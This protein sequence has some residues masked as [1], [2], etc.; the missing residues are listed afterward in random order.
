M[1]IKFVSF[2]AFIFITIASSCKSNAQQ[3]PLSDF[4][5]TAP[6][7]VYSDDWYKLD[8]SLLQF[9]VYNDNGI[10]RLDKAPQEAHAEL[11]VKGGKLIGINNGEWG[12]ELLYIVLKHKLQLIKRGNIKFIFKFNKQICFIEGLAHGGYNGGAL[13]VLN[14]K[15]SSFTFKKLIDFDDSPQAIAI[16]NNKLLVASFNGFSV[17]NGLKKE[18]IFN[19]TFWSSLRPNSIVAIN[20]KNIFMGIVGGYVKIDLTNR[21]YTFFK[22]KKI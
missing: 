13:Y 5:E 17:V 22:Y 14:Q 10:L 8:Y 11:A 4:I 19:N 7:A 3:Y 18:T 16:Y 15:D 21:S 9:Q 6:P 12:G 20:D 2:I 1:C